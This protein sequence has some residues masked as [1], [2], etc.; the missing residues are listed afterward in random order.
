MSIFPVAQDMHTH[1]FLRHSPGRQI[2]SKIKASRNKEK[3][4]SQT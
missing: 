3:A 1:S 2:Q 4:E